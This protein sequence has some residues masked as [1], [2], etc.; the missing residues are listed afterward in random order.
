MSMSMSM[1]RNWDRDMDT[2]ID[3][4]GVLYLRQLFV[5]TFAIKLNCIMKKIV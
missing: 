4:I 3:I 2:D 1:N 5:I